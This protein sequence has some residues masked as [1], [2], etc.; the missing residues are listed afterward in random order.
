MVKPANYREM[1]DRAAVD[2]KSTFIKNLREHLELTG[3]SQKALARRLDL[4]E[5]A[6]SEFLRMPD[7]CSENL[8]R[9]VSITIKELSGEYMRYRMYVDAPFFEAAEKQQVA[10]NEMQVLAMHHQAVIQAARDI[11]AVLERLKGQV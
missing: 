6:M 9:I 1:Y 8:I 3:M 5:T 4:S 7:H 2:A 10:M 11:N